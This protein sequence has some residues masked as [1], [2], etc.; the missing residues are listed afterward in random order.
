MG[1]G[2]ETVQ[3]VFE[4]VKRKIHV[5]MRILRSNAVFGS[6]NAVSE[7]SDA[8][9][10]NCVGILL[11]AAFGGLEAAFGSGIELRLAAV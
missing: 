7:S 6:L 5:L 4:Q 1:N 9:A 2:F 8:V 10:G 11:E 3:L